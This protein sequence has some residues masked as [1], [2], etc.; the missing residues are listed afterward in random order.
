VEVLH[1]GYI[2]AVSLQSSVESGEP[3]QRGGNDP[4]GVQGLDAR[5]RGLVELAALGGYQAKVNASNG[6]ACWPSDGA[7]PIDGMGDDVARV[8]FGT[9]CHAKQCVAGRGVEGELGR[10]EGEV[11]FWMAGYRQLRK[12]SSPAP[13][14]ILGLALIAQAGH[15]L[16]SWTANCTP[17]DV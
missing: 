17:A 2:R 7:V 13:Q 8:L 5:V 12:G 10:I 9:V 1:L 14:G 4:T 3:R 16:A 6:K 11:M 15:T